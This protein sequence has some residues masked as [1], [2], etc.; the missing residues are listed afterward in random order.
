MFIIDD[1]HDNNR[2]E[3][4][5]LL[6][7]NAAD[8]AAQSLEQVIDSPVAALAPSTHWVN[9]NNLRATLAGLKLPE[10]S[11][12][13]RQSFRGHLRGE[14]LVLLEHGAKHY[15]LGRV[16]GYEAEMTPLNIQELTLE[17]A[18][19]LSGACISG[20]SQQLNIRLNFGAPSLLSNKASVD[21]I[22]AGKTLSWTDA[23]FMDLGYTVSSINMKAHLI[24]CIVEEDSQ[25]LYQCID[26]QL[27]NA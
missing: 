5:Q 6:L 10:K 2:Q 7:N 1:S 13:I 15:Q 22:L 19:V 23:L 26:Q 20:L 14:V 11:I 27:D 17:L 24:L 21:S 25:V 18:N 12:V 16:M 4:V 3:A 9:K 8:T